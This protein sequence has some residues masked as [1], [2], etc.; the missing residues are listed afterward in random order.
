MKDTFLRNALV[1]AI[2]AAICCFTPI[3]VWILPAVGL[4]AALGYL[5]V[6]LLPALVVCLGLAGYALWR[7]KNT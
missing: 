7:R 4:S 2:V 1:G 5:D 6:V 3:L